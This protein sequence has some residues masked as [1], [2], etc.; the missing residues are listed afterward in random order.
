MG[1]KPCFKCGQEK[2]LDQFYAH[3]QMGDGRLN[4][5]IDCT[6]MDARARRFDPKF[7]ERVLRYDRERGNRQ[8]KAYRD[9]VRQKMPTETV[10]RYTLSNAVRDGKIIR[11]DRCSH[12][13]VVG[14]LHG[15]HHDYSKPLDVVWL[16]VPCHRQLHAF[17]ATIQRSS[18][19]AN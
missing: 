3:P 15:H 2:T 10:A 13:H 4:K 9:S 8:D 12:C 1:V 11:P 14:P 18:H 7:R 5:C 6:K 16:C 19:V 17:M